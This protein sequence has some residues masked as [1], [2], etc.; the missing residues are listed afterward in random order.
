MDGHPICLE[1]DEDSGDDIILDLNPHT[2]GIPHGTIELDISDGNSIDASN[3]NGSDLSAIVVSET[4]HTITYADGMTYEKDIMFEEREEVFEIENV[5]R[6]STIKPEV[7]RLD[8]PEHIKNTAVDIFEQMEGIG[9]KRADNRKMIVFACIYYA[10]LECDTVPFP[11][12]LCNMVGLSVKKMAKALSSVS[13]EKTGYRPP[14]KTFGVLDYV[15]PLLSKEDYSD[16]IYENIAKLYN[17]IN[18]RNPTIRRKKPQEVAKALLTCYRTING[19]VTEH[20]NSKMTELEKC[21]LSSV[22]SADS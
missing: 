2:A 8:I 18:R 4:A 17:E 16:E 11:A 15:K 5:S 1:Y 13:F 22:I 6:C 20:D 9:I 12:E 10:H 3:V 14:L 7:D 19:I 21:I